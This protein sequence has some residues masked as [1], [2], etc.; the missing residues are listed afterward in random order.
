MV[1]RI[2]YRMGNARAAE[3]VVEASSP[4]EAVVKFRH[5]HGAGRPGEQIT[6]VSSDE[7]DEPL[8]HPACED[9]VW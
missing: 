8:M 1:Y 5:A 9:T 3:A 2:R 7:L 6:S 4:T